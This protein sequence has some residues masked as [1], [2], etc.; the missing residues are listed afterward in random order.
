MFKMANDRMVTQQDIAKYCGVSQRAVSQTLLN[1]GRISE[2]TRQRILAAA[3]ELG[4]DLSL[5][6]VARRLRQSRNGQRVINHLVAVI[7]PTAFQQSVYFGRILQGI[8]EVLE[9]EPFS[10][11][12]EQFNS[13]LPYQ[14]SPCFMSGDID[15]VII[16]EPMQNS[17]DVVNQLWQMPGFYERAVVSLMS[18]MNNCSS[19]LFDDTSAAHLAASQLLDSGHRHILAFLDA[20]SVNIYQQ[21]VA[22]IRQAYYE[23]NLNPDQ[24]LDMQYWQLGILTAPYHLAIPDIHTPD[25]IV[26]FSPDGGFNQFI[27]YLESHPEITAIIAQ[28]DS[29]ARRIAYMLT[30]AG[31]RI[32]EQ[33]SL[34]SFDD[35]DPLLNA[36]GH[37]ILTTV[38][39]PLI[40][41]GRE[42]IKMLIRQINEPDSEPEKITLKGEIIIRNSTRDI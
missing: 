21:R 4:Y 29:V 3:T 17:D 30:Q 25:E 11:V 18:P 24:Y 6:K 35:T 19:V 16:Y 26:H 13:Y 39:L 2:A 23:R 7:L 10:M 42:A 34:V 14:F 12:I 36:F 27:A 28:N 40:E 20:R 32:P 15:G 38:H 5:Q 33:L 37:N 1:E 22:G 8:T 41:V 31:W 9:N